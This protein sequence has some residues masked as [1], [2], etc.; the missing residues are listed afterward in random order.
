M[1][2][3]NNTKISKK[4]VFVFKSSNGSNVSKTHPLDMTM[5]NATILNII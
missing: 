5:G 3:L 1:K 4:T 2:V